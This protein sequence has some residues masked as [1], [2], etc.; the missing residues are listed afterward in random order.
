M[1][2]DLLSIAASGLLAAQRALSTTGNNLA[3][4]STEGYSRQRVEL[5][6]RDP[7]FTGGGYVGNG[8]NIATIARSYDNFL[9]TQVRTSQSASGG[10]AAYDQMA[11]Q[12]DKLV[13]D[14]NSGLPSSLQTFFNGLQGVAND[15]TST[16]AR[17]VL[18]SRGESLANR[19]NSLNG[20]LNTLRD[21]T[22]QSLSSGVDQINTWAAGIATLNTQIVSA[23]AYGKGQPPNDLIDQRNLLVEKLSAK[24]DTSVM[25]KQDGTIDVFIGN[26]QSLVMGSAANRLQTQ[27]SAYDA[28]TRDIA[29]AT[30]NQGSIVITQSLTGGEMGGLLKFGREV[31]DPAQNSLGRIA[32]GLGL[33]VNAQHTQGTDQNGNPGQ[34]FFTDPTTPSDSWFG[35]S[36]N[37]GNA[38][39]SVA[40]DSTPA[41]ATAPA[42]GPAQLTASDYRLDFDGS[43]NATLT[44]LSD[45][46]KFTANP[47]A[48]GSFQVDG[49]KIAVASGAA[50]AGDSFLIEPFRTP[51]GTLGLALND[52]SRIA[53]A[54]KP[55]TGSGDNTNALALAGL[56][57]AKGLLGGTATVQSA[58]SQLIGNVAT[59]ANA[60]G[61]DSTAQKK[62]LDQATQS[63]ESVSGVNLDEEAANLVRFQ[64]AYQAS[65]Q[66]IP[67]LNNTFNALLSAIR[68]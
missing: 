68:S 19:F 37:T 47:P 31:L 35:K 12:V 32:A 52:P 57:T 46:T 41:S 6:E 2:G 43:G 14:S 60:A 39:L 44:R 15:P 5:A 8:V 28:R 54:G 30:G 3:N 64:Q 17:Q 1:A 24:V 65:A 42:N 34:N 49:L 61:V 25:A 53:A 33:A 50:S 9:N 62:L 58:Y 67:A 16:A 45:N 23:T 29:I 63:R 56:Q 10:A 36:S 7:S 26:G 51:A 18:L 13:G 38:Q 27:A 40:F 11:T 48:S 66:L 22:Q 4:A 55:P 20:Q 21:Q 59:Q